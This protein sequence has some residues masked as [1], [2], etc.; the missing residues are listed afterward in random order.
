MLPRISARRALGERPAL[1]ED[2]DAVADLHD[3]RHVVIDQQHARLVRRRGRSG[4]RRRRRAS[5][6]RAARLPARPSARTAAQ[7][8][9]PRDTELA[10]VAVRER[11]RGRPGAATRGRAVRAARPHASRR[12][13]P[14][15]RRRARPPR[16]SRAREPAER[17]GRAGTCARARARPRRSGG[18]P[19]DVALRE[20]TAPGVG[21]VEASEELTS[22]VLPAPFGPIRPTTSVP[23][24][25]EVT[26][27]KRVDALERARDAGGPE[28]AVRAAGSPHARASVN[29]ARD[30]PASSR[31]RAGGTSASSS[32]LG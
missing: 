6:P 11:G 27:L 8:Q 9:R 17:G 7:R 22:V 23:L 2:V 32:A 28:R 19:R 24:Q 15:P 20:P 4:R 3:Q 18:Q 25:L 30:C 26:P 10:L 12:R 16:R 14:T 13:A 21:Q 31:C 5:R 29:S 1:V